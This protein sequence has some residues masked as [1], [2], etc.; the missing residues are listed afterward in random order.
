MIPKSL[1]IFPGHDANLPTQLWMASI[2]DFNLLHRWEVDRDDAGLGVP[3]I[4]PSR[5]RQAWARSLL[6]APLIPP[7]D[8][9]AGGVWPNSVR[10]SFSGARI[11]GTLSGIEPG[12]APN[13][14]PNC[15]SDDC[16]YDEGKA[17]LTAVLARSADDLGD[18]AMQAMAL[19]LVQ[20]TLASI[21]ARRLPM[22]KSQGEY[23]GRMTSAVARLALASSDPD[24][25]FVDGFEN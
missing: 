15:G 10:F 5:A 3:A 7:G 17:T 12:W 22:G 23:F 11:G 2:Y 25:L 1:L 9:T 8:G 24:R 19:G 6:D 21:A 16:L 4:A 18:P 13:S 14:A 20:N